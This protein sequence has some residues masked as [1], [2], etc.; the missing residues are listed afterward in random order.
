MVLQLSLDF[1]CSFKACKRLMMSLCVHDCACHPGM[2]QLGS[3]NRNR[4]PNKNDLDEF[5]AKREFTPEQ[6]TRTQHGTQDHSFHRHHQ[7]TS[8][9]IDQILGLYK[10]KMTWWPG[11]WKGMIPHLCT[12][13]AGFLSCYLPSRRLTLG[14]LT[15]R[16]KL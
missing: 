10:V 9:A 3:A 1:I 15:S 11:F 13:C 2:L 4:S 14:S 12:A 7:Q 16:G 8:R 6:D 5:A